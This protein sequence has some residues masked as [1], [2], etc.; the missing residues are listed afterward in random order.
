MYYDLIKVHGVESLFCKG[1]ADIDSDIDG[2][3]IYEISEDS[4]TGKMKNICN[5][6]VFYLYGTIITTKPIDL[7]EG[8]CGCVSYNSDL[9]IIDFSGDSKITLEEYLHRIKC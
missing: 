1:R 2:I 3:Y 6:G 5:C 4:F 7:N 9:R 8:G